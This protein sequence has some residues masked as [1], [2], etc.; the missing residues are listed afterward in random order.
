MWL[1][2]HYCAGDHL[3]IDFLARTRDHFS[4][5]ARASL[6]DF[7]TPFSG[8]DSFMYVCHHPIKLCVPFSPLVW[9]LMLPLA[10]STV[11]WYFIVVNFARVKPPLQFNI[12]SLLQHTIGFSQHTHTCC[13]CRNFSLFSFCCKSDAHLFP[14][15]C[16]VAPFFLDKVS[17]TM[18]WY[19]HATKVNGNVA[20]NWS[21]NWMPSYSLKCVLDRDL[22]SSKYLQR[23]A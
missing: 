18:H 16:T 23:L 13:K 2:P 15:L 7:I 11:N 6:D 9:R 14:F 20:L 12:G 5:R 8:G 19:L 4:S 10:P 1:Q 17:S 3:Q 22:T 21:C